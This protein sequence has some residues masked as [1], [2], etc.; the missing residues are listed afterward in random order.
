MLTLSAF[1]VFFE[2]VKKALLLCGIPDFVVL[3]LEPTSATRY[4]ASLTSTTGYPLALALASA[5]LGWSGLSVICQTQA[6]FS[7]T[8]PLAMQIKTRAAIALFSFVIA[9]ALACLF[10]FKS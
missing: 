6:L 1:V 7:G 2:V 10:S 9:Y 5:A 8:L 4:A 3:F